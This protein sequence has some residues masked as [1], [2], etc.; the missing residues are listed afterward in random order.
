MRDNTLN[1]IRLYMRTTIRSWFQYRVDALLRS[2]A[3]F[4]RESAGVIAIYFTLLK[5]DN[6]N[7]WGLGKWRS[8]TA[9]F[10]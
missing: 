2:V 7:G 10:F 9:C 6:L 4:L 8:C 1:L 3:V 5:F